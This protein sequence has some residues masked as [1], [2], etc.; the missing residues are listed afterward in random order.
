MFSFLKSAITII[1]NFYINRLHMCVIF[2]NCIILG[3][4]VT[5]IVYYNKYITGFPPHTD[6]N[7]RHRL[8]KYIIVITDISSYLHM[9]FLMFS[10]LLFLRKPMS[11]LLLLNLQ[12]QNLPIHTN[13]IYSQ[14][15]LK[16]HYI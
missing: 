9:H 5:T 3:Q 2:T 8:S 12:S 4:G 6:T 16:M 15:F 10:N 7:M 1:D 13:K 14:L 11:L